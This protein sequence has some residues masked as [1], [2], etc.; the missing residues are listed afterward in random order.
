MAAGEITLHADRTDQVGALYSK[1][2][3]VAPGSTVVIR[4]QVFVHAASRKFEGGLTAFG[5]TDTSLSAGKPSMQQCRFSVGYRNFDYETDQ[6]LFTLTDGQVYPSGPGKFA[7]GTAPTTPPQWDQ[8]F[9]E[10]VRYHS[11]TGETVY[12][13]NGQE[14]MR[15]KAR[16][17]DQP[18]LKLLLQPYGWGTG[19]FVRM[20]G[21]QVSV[22]KK[23]AG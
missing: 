23:C 20:R 4:R 15:L 1:P 6:N 10:E 22:E 18:Y 19:H 5:V 17:L 14:R 8:W 13:I 16:P 12:L 9:D 3:A 2:I 21:F 7:G 11:G